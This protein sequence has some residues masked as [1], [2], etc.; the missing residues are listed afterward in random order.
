MNERIR[1]LRA[2]W[3]ARKNGLLQAFI[4]GLSGDE[5]NLLEPNIQGETAHRV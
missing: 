4:D 1:L 3:D 5:F 2:L